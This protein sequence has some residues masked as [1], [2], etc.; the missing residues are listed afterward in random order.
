MNNSVVICFQQQQRTEQGAYDSTDCLKKSKKNPSEF[1]IRKWEFVKPFDDS[2]IPQNAEFYRISYNRSNNSINHLVHSKIKLQNHTD[3]DI[4]MD[5]TN[6]DSRRLSLICAKMRSSADWGFAVRGITVGLLLPP[7]VHEFFCK[8]SL[9][10]SPAHSQPSGRGQAGSP[11]PVQPGRNARKT[12][13]D[14]SVQ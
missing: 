6:P 13:W 12:S 14:K 8:V 4:H 2:W 10:P 7:R 9:Q 1:R 5:F 11:K 3:S